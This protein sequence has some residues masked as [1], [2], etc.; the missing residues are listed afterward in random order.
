MVIYS[1][2]LQRELDPRFL[3]LDKGY[4]KD[5]QKIIHHDEVP[6]LD[7]VGHYETVK[8][9]SN[10]GKEIKWVTDI[11][12]QEYCAAWDE[13]IEYQVYIP[14]STQYLFNRGLKK[15]IEKQ[16]EKLANSDYKILKYI[17]GLYTEEEFEKIKKERQKYRD[18]IK[19]LEKRFIPEE[20]E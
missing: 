6:Q 12:A 16:K 9:Y 15:Q 3:D 13:V 4:L 19:D 14:Y 1:Q 11:E 5:C 8:E 7:E 20:E 18:N 2:D 17:E 10:G